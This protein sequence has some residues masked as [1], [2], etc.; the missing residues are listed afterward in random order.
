MALFLLI[1][2]KKEKLSILFQYIQKSIGLTLL[3]FCDLYLIYQLLVNI[4]HSYLKI[5]AN[6]NLP[7]RAKQQGDYESSRSVHGCLLGPFFLLRPNPITCKVRSCDISK[8]IFSSIC[9]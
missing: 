3:F 5:V 2:E 4:I 1:I 7:S 9:M 8:S 6:R